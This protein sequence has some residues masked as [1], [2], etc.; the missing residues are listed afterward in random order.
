MTA[1]S[2][3]ATP[4]EVPRTTLPQLFLDAVRAHGSE[5]AYAPAESPKIS[6]EQILRKVARGAL[7]LE[8]AGLNRGDRA[9]ILSENRLE[10][11]I[12]DW[13]CLM[14]GVV[15]VPIYD[16]L[17][18][19]RIAYILRDSG[20]K[21]I[22]VSSDEMASKAREAAKELSSPLDIVAFDQEAAAKGALAWEEFLGEVNVSPDEAAPKL[23]EAAALAGPDDLCTLI[24]TSGTTG[25]PKGVM[26]SHGNIAGNVAASSRVIAI[27][28]GDCSISF[29]P[30]SH[31][32]QR[33]VDYMM[34][35]KGCA[36]T[37]S[38]IGDL[39]GAL[40][41]V[42]PT[43]LVAVP[44]VYEKVH[45]ALRERAGVG[46]R[47]AS[48]A[49]D[50]ATGAGRAIDEDA[51]SRL[52]SRIQ[53][54]LADRLVLSKVRAK[55]GGRIRFFVSGGAKLAPDINRF[56]LGSKLPIYE[57]YG[58][59]ETSPVTNVNTSSHSRIGTVGQPIPGTEIRIAGD[60]EV[61][62]RGP[63][64][65]MGYHGM[66]EET[67]SAISPDGWFRTGDVGELTQDGFLRI[68]DRKKDLI[69]TAGG[70]FV[71]P[72]QVENLA[73]R[74]ALVEEAVLVG[75][76]R[77]FCSLLVVPSREL[78]IA[79]FDADENA[80]VGELVQRPDVQAMIGREVLS[81]FEELARHEAPKKILLLPEP[82]SVQDGSLT[83]TQKVV[84]RTVEA[85]WGDLIAQ[86]YAPESR[87][88]T[89]FAAGP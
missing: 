7:A 19:K 85:A 62:V 66:E 75:E 49:V 17:P 60:G 2:S 47:I 54:A 51:P 87:E 64:V 1:R 58:L 29:L 79:A 27:S 70:K 59:T 45:Q 15:D 82:F 80:E 57:G 65:M 48:W 23:E 74:S 26:L 76:G 18:P 83:P 67:R 84:R 53:L 71:A 63:Q 40:A 22:F 8:A 4:G 10:W 35:A 50:I 20:A 11:A 72:Q 42:R 61:L 16:T 28:R 25:D 44:R 30:L 5:T 14:A 78:L 32:L 36:V 68:T 52:W 55:M 86:L 9:A 21:L 56:F 6:Y 69:K 33:M 13:S 73:K 41:A 34:F 43:V 37:H 88:R 77:P 39:M 46:G 81:A 89:V 31:T 12:A 38:V 3:F 24:Y